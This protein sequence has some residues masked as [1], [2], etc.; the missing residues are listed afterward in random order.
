MWATIPQELSNNGMRMLV[1][2]GQL[3]DGIMKSSDI[4]MRFTSETENKAVLG[5]ERTAVTEMLRTTPIAL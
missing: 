1:S 4:F 3:L 5:S 2:F